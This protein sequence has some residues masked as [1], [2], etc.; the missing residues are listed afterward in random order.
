MNAI[1]YTSEPP[2]H[3][4]SAERAFER[5]VAADLRFITARVTANVGPSLAA[6]L[7]C[8]GYGRGEGGAVERDGALV[9]YN[10]YDLVAVV[11]G[12]ARP[13]RGELLTLAHAL[14]REV[15]L[16][17]ELWPVSRK[18]LN[19][20][21]KTLFWLDVA[22]GGVRVLHGDA[23]VLGA[24]RQLAPRDVPLEEAGRLLANRAVGLALSRLEG[25]D[26]RDAGARHLHKAALAVGDAT[27]LAA[28]R[29]AGSIRERASLLGTTSLSP[30]LVTAY[31]DAA[32]FRRRP[33]RAPWPGDAE[34]GWL[35]ERL[36]LLGDAHLA[37][38]ARRVGSPTNPRDFARFRGAVYPTLGAS[39]GGRARAVG[40]SLVT[41]ARGLNPLDGW[42][43]H[44]R[45]RIARVAVAIAY[46]DR[47]AWNEGA[48]LLGMAPA[49]R[50]GGTWAHELAAR[51][52]ALLP[53]GG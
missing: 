16:E 24:V 11:D 7:L 42:F 40:A 19:P 13:L 23:R 53:S 10:D 26:D 37:F 9:P 46:G 25:F 44:P 21:P 45:E 47:A 4:N 51:L 8:G 27:L 41:T 12:A 6:L 3:R 1:D 38:E 52:R 30:A 5:S 17:V 48:R 32:A 36:A 22:L 34:G 20:A 35:E 49:P 39:L 29:Y 14:T 15:G 50:D 31:H 43:A 28:G 2:A 33:D 18:E